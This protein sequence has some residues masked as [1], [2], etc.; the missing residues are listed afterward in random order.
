MLFGVG[1]LVFSAVP[2]SPDIVDPL[3][4]SPVNNQEISG[5]QAFRGH[6]YSSTSKNVSVQLFIAGATVEIPWNA[7]QRARFFTTACESRR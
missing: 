6:V 2:A 3:W 4:E 1:L 5:L 7:A